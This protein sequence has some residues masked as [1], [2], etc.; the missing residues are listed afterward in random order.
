[1]LH[2]KFYAFLT[3]LSLLALAVFGGGGCGGSSSSGGGSS[4]P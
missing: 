1:M 3:A 4:S 2:K